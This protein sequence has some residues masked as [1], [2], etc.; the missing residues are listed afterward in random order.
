MPRSVLTDIETLIGYSFWRGSTTEVVTEDHDRPR[1][2]VG[3]QES[4][5]MKVVTELYLDKVAR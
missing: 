2:R 5:D 3:L 4:S 1:L